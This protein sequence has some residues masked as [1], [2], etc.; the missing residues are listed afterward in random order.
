MI[1]MI[2]L[3]TFIPGGKGQVSKS[4]Q[5]QAT[6]TN[7][8][9]GSRGKSDPA[10]R[11]DNRQQH[12][13]RGQ[14]QRRSALRRTGWNARHKPGLTGRG[15]YCAGAGLSQGGDKLPRPVEDG[16]QPKY[17]SAKPVV[18]RDQGKGVAEQGYAPAS[19]EAAKEG[20]YFLPWPVM[21]SAIRDYNGETKT[22]NNLGD[23]AEEQ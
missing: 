8:D 11:G 23:G 16:D 19:P 1:G 9:T 3:S 7:Q 20:S 2:D 21:S 6:Q 13:S 15:G 4:G 10:G 5:D 12:A 22:S 14:S 18:D 17:K